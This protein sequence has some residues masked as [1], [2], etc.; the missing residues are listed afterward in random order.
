VRSFGFA[1]A[2][3]RT[4]I[5]SQPNYRIHLLAAI[6][7]LGAGLLLR[8]SPAELALLVLTVALVLA[9]EALNTAIE[10][11]CDLVSPAYHPLVKRAK[12][13][14]AAAVLITAIASVVIAALLLLPH[15]PR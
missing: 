2:G 1:F 5:R 9:A 3:L 12:D 11:V 6:V 10:T 15:L 8:L 14:S 7:A 4:V 13:A